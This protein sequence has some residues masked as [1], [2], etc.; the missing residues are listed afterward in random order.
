[1]LDYRKEFIK[2]IGLTLVLHYKSYDGPLLADLSCDFKQVLAIKRLAVFYI[3]SVLMLSQSSA[4]RFIIMM[5]IMGAVSP[6]DSDCSK[7][8]H[9]LIN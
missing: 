2:Q 6:F 9:S 3:N 5:I 8:Q 1:M 4:Y 7:V